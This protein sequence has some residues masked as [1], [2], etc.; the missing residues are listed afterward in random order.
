MSKLFS[1]V[2]ALAVCVTVV[3]VSSACDPKHDP[4][5]DN[6][7]DTDGPVVLLPI[8]DPISTP[9]AQ[10][11]AKAPCDPKYDPSCD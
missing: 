9:D 7:H 2:A 3:A 1:A 4:G 6:V 11:V 8:A 10:P 5:C